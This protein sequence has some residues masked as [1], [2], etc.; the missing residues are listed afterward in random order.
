MCGFLGSFGKNPNLYDL[1]PHLKTLINRGPDFQDFRVIDEYC[2]MGVARLAMTDPHPRSNQ[3]MWDSTNNTVISF[4][5]E[6]YNFLDIRKKL[7]KEGCEFKTESDTEVLLTFLKINES[8]ALKRIKGMYAF[9]FYDL[10]TNKLILSRDKLGKKP[11]YYINRN[12]TIFWSSSI[13]IL[14]DIF[15]T[16]PSSLR[17]AVDY[18]SLGYN[19]DPN[20]SYQEINAVMPGHSIEFEL[21][22]GEI[23]STDSLNGLFADAHSVSIREALW[24]AIEDRTINHTE[25]A[26]SL[27][28]GVDSTL[29]GL[30]LAHLGVTADA[31]SA[32]WSDS[33]KERYNSDRKCAEI[34]AAELGHRFH[35]VDVSEG[36]ELEPLLREFLTAMEEPYNNPT[37]LSTLQLY[38]AIARDGHRLLLTGDGSDEVFAGYK[39]HSLSMKYPRIFKND[40]S[41]FIDFL[42]RSDYKLVG[43]LKNSLMSQVDP[44][45]PLYW[46]NWHWV[47]TPYEQASLLNN[48]ISAKSISRVLY[49]EIE[50]ISSAS[51]SNKAVEILMKRDH[52]VWLSMESNRKLDRLSMYFSVEARSPF[53]DEDLI[54]S[55][56]K[57]M[58]QSNF[59]VLD[60]GTL[61]NEFPELDRLSVKKEKDGF[62]SPVGHWMR[63]NP[64]F[65]KD[66][67]QYL[68][69][70]PEWNRSAIANFDN[71][72]FKGDYKTNLKLWTLTV[73]ST[74]IRM[75]NGE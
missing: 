40:G 66:S 23:R 27:S 63:E 53:Q 38:R 74:W 20:T 8:E 73:Y 12:Q 55:A 10:E 35:P 33:D 6:I 43:I 47:F 15:E 67:L 54:A 68:G 57:I 62:T 13:K 2:H 32:F 18:L 16:N 28:G 24:K 9:A 17:E 42:S 7:E 75:L 52:E 71:S 22:N 39:R 14:K 29:I 61:K 64:E 41:T 72:Q 4:N 3:P 25:V 31:Y 26:L 5:G 45:T 51:N 69:N 58:D 59:K 36:F 44:K 37:G 48:Q 21:I 1:S 70:L 19:L 50:N 65:I 60:K 34:I 56:N 46:L 11:L 49:K 30:G